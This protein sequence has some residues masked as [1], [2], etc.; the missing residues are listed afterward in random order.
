MV[1]IVKEYFNQISEV[2]KSQF[3]S[4]SFGVHDFIDII[5]V[6]VL[7]YY[8]YKF[9]RDKR[10]AKLALGV[11]F[12]MLVKV[13]T[14]VFSLNALGFIINNFFQIG[15][16]AIVIIFQPELRSALEQAGGTSLKGFKNF[17]E[18]HNENTVK[19]VESVC[20]AVCEMA[21]NKTGALI[22]F[23]NKTGLNDI[24][25]SGTVINADFSSYLLRNI[26]F[27]NTPLHDGAVVIREG[28]IYAA[29]CYLPLSDNPNI[30]K[31]LGTRH[32]AAI[33]MSEISDAYILVVSEETGTISITHRGEIKRNFDYV[34]L[35]ETLVQYL[36]PSEEETPKIK[37]NK[38]IAKSFDKGEKVKRTPQTTKKKYLPKDEIEF[39]MFDGESEE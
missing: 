23:E 9:I 19:M 35:K 30:A 6:A 39:D 14:D 10:A 4:F 26:F 12:I 17:G 28:R 8:V 13:L 38:K 37:F 2:F 7:L 32:R 27:E 20:D 16:L 31:E 36:I 11:F 25:S 29:G 18:K 22:V 34:S 15:L 5:V 33:G 24:I 1:I 3:K 21:K